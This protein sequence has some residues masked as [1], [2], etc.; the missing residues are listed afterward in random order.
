MKKKLKSLMTPFEKFFAL[1]AASGL[2]LL[3]C[4][5]LALVLANS[6]LAGAFTH[7]LHLPL[8]IG[9]GAYRLEMSLTHWVNDGLMTL[10]FFAIGL[11]IKREFLYGELRT[12]AAMVLPVCAALG[13][14]VIPALLYSLINLGAPTAS[15]WGIPMATDIA[16]AL[17]ILSLAAREAPLG[18]VVFLT[19][20]AIVDDLGAIVVIALFYSSGIALAPLGAGLLALALAAALGKA[21]ARSLPLYG[22]LGLAAWGAFLA[23]GIHP[24]IAGVLLGFTIPAAEHPEDSLLHRLEERLE[25]WSAYVIMPVFALA[26]AGVSLADAALDPASPLFLGIV[27]GLVIGKPL[28]IFGSACLLTRRLGAP[29]PG[30]ARPAQALAAGTLGGIGFTMSIFIANLAFEDAATLA[31]AKLSILSASVLAGLL[32]AALFRLTGKSAPPAA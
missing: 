7:L 29:L 13:G 25:P 21:G 10:F 15:G 23:S 17:G 1:E 20:L 16:F 12:K 26:N 4:A 28:G 6:P 19:A 11:E 2:V 9:S 14:M 22:V 5:L 31:A 32:G 24:T 30:G 18:L 27:C 8:G 3:A